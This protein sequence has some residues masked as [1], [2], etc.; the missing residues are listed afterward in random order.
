MAVSLIE[1][2]KLSTVVAFL[3][4][5]YYAQR[6]ANYTQGGAVYWRM[7]AISAFAIAFS[8]VLE[9]FSV[10]GIFGQ[11]LRLYQITGEI[12]RLAAGVTFGY[13]IYGMYKMISTA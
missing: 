8:L 7:L 6:L 12:I 3:L 13:F 4:S 5:A 11:D 9:I 1:I 10:T 2:L